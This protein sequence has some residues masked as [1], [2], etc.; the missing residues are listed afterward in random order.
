[1]AII[2]ETIADKIETLEDGQVQIRT[3]TVIKEDGTELTRTF[4]RHVLA[5]SD[6]SSGSW[7]DTDISGEDA[8]VQTIC[9]AVWTS[10]VKTAYQEAFDANTP[11]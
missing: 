2:K 10:A 7:A 6:K 3:A 1:M 8:R 5:P 4:H 11:S 9:N